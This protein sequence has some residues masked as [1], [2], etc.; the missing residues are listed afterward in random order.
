MSKIKDITKINTSKIDVKSL[1][2]S[3]KT[4]NDFLKNKK[5]VKK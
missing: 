1:E 3:I 4:K 2:K 5:V